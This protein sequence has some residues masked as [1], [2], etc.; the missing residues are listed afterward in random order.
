MS[1]LKE[2]YAEHGLEISNQELPDYLPVYLDFIST[3]DDESEALSYLAD[4][5]ELIK[6]I[7]ESLTK[8]E[9]DY[10]LLLKPLIA[11]AAKGESHPL[12]ETESAEN[13]C[14]FAK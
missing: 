7:Y 8:H 4:I 13:N 6:S 1:S 10:A 9:S 3:L 14:P 12:P 5:G 11:L 2:T